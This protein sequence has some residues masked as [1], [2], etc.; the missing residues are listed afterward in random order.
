M[1]KPFEFVASLLNEAGHVDRKYGLP[2]GTAA[3]QILGLAAGLAG[4]QFR[5]SRRGEDRAVRIPLIVATGDPVMP[6]WMLD[7]WNVAL[8]LQDKMEKHER[9]ILGARLKPHEH[10]ELRRTRDTLAGLGWGFEKQL[11]EVERKLAGAKLTVNIDLLHEVGRHGGRRNDGRPP[12]G[13]SL[14]VMAKGESEIRSLV[15]AAK[16]GSPLWSSLEHGGLP[17]YSMHSWCNAG[18][19]H[20]AFPPDPAT[21][22]SRVGYLLRT[23]AEITDERILLVRANTSHLLNMIR[24]QRI[25]GR[26]LYLAPLPE[27]ESLLEDACDGLLAGLPK[28]YLHQARHTGI[29]T[30]LVW[31]FATLFLSLL[32]AEV[33]EDDDSP[34]DGVRL[35]AGLG[36]RLLVDHLSFLSEIRPM[37]SEGPLSPLHRSFMNRLGYGPSTIRELQRAQR[38]VR[39]NCCL[40][41]LGELIDLGLVESADHRSYRLAPPPDPGLSEILSEFIEKHLS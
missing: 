13:N 22:A 7:P 15:G 30:D 33:G 12:I 39:K 8:D 14:L 31:H 32:Q 36:R 34:H 27:I 17:G 29:S 19:I 1:I 24:D 2:A 4:N 5:F 21:S 20:S 38:G 28:G 26:T 37:G 25:S 6:G 9:S 11:Q 41:I 23:G 35:A 16:R 10:R 3:I 40:E 18:S